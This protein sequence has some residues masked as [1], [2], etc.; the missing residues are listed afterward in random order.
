MGAC[1][2]L[3]I[4]DQP[5]MLDLLDKML[6]REGFKVLRARDARSALRVAYEH[7]P[8]AMLVDV[9]MADVDGFALCE[10]L[11][12][13]TDVP[14]LFMT[15]EHAPED[16]LRGFEAGADDYVV[17]P[18]SCSELLHRLRACLRRAEEGQTE[19]PHMFFSKGA[20]CL[21]HDHH[22]LTI[23]DRVID[24]TPKEC[25]VMRLL[26][27]HPGRV[28]SEKAILWRVWGEA[29]VGDTGLV[30]QYIHRL[31]MKIEAHP[32]SPEYL[33]TVWGG[34]YYFDASQTQSI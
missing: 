3:V 11:R 13:V 12:D 17:K 31:R 8:N 4:D 21:D 2:V 7:R 32:E 28:L 24:L 15:A 30:K 19:G 26:L 10:R 14:I 20:V 9:T 34:G 22:Q 5:E 33:H 27:R 1:R 16:V 25:E 23:G 18:F 29:Q 6:S